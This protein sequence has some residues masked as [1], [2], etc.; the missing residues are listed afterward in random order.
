[1]WNNLKTLSERRE[2][3]SKLLIQLLESDGDTAASEQSFKNS[4]GKSTSIVKS[5]MHGVIHITTTN[6]VSLN[7]VFPFDD[8]DGSESVFSDKDYVCFVC[9][10]KEKRTLFFF[11]SPDKLKGKTSIERSKL[12]S[13][14]DFSGIEK[15]GQFKISYKKGKRN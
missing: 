14:S 13:N 12:V 10:D 15:N 5:K 6:S 8:G 9:M 3:A 7:G 11:V 4:K 1:M 2:A